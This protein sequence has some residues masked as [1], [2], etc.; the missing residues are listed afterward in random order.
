MHSFMTGIA[1]IIGIWFALFLISLAVDLF[2]A[3]RGSPR[4]TAPTVARR[5]AKCTILWRQRALTNSLPSERYSVLWRLKQEKLLR[6]ALMIEGLLYEDALSIS[7][8][9]AHETW[10]SLG[11]VRRL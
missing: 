5:T 1:V 4:G 3:K 11:P 2:Q 8:A 10:A 7:H 9:V 6:V